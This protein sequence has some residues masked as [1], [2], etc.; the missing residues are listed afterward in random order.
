MGHRFL[1]T[2]IAPA[3]LFGAGAQRPEHT[4][5]LRQSDSAATPHFELVSTIAFSNTFGATRDEQ[6]NNA[7]I[8]LLDPDGTNP[9]QLTDNQA[10]DA[11]PTLSPNGKKI[12]FDSN[13][14]RGSGTVEHLGPVRDEH[15]RHRA[16]TPDPRCLADVVAGQ[17]ADRLPRLG[18]GNRSADPDHHPG[19][20]RS[21]SDLFIAD[22]DD[23]LTGVEAPRNVTNTPDHIDD[24][25]DWSPDGRTP[26]SPAT[27]S[28]ATT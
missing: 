2:A 16:D 6:F 25:P 7:E 8:F 4:Q 24:D 15:R 10:A 18:V 12:V 9:R 23:L 21:D 1:L 19:R 28:T 3:M 14:L 5:P 22:V 20:R 27:T 26:S 17:Q 11:F 13:R